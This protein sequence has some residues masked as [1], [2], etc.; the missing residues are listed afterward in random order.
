MIFF[1]VYAHQDI[2]FQNF[3]P[4]ISTTRAEH[5]N[6]PC[7]DKATSGCT[8]GALGNHPSVNSQ[9]WH[10]DRLF[11]SLCHH[12]LFAPC[13]RPLASFPLAAGPLLPRSSAVS[14]SRICRSRVW[15][16]VQ[17]SFCVCCAAV[18]VPFR[19]LY[20]AALNQA[21]LHTLLA[22]WREL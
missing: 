3:S 7:W 19:C 22:C 12:N 14:C 13:R 10:F 8:H 20:S 21:I 9:L 4:C 5:S 17:L 15:S 11:S 18:L 2:L 16:F 6:P 1:A